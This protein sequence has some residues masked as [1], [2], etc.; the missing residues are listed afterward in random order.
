MTEEM[1]KMDFYEAYHALEETVDA[2]EAP[3]IKLD[4]SI[5]LYEHA[6]ELVV[7]CRER[8]AEAKGKI[9]DINERFSSVIKPG[10]KPVSKTITKTVTNHGAAI[11]D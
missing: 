3:G 2:L 7:C 1:K 8:L 5:K 10:T 4:E 11:P 6:C 9:T